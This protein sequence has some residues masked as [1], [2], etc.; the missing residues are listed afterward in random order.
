MSTL[1][2]TGGR[3]LR[4]RLRVP[5]DKS[6]S[7]RALLLAARAKGTSVIRGLSSGDDVSRTSTAIE[8]L[9]AV[10]NGSQVTGGLRLLHE[11]GGVI[12]VG[13]SGT[14]IRLLAGLVAAFGWRTELRGDAS[15]AARPMDRVTTPLRLMGARVDGREDG[16]FPPL[17]VH[18]GRL[19]GI[20]YTPPVA[21]AQAKSAVL[22][23]GLG[24]DGE[25]IVREPVPT[26]A[27][28]EELLAACG[29][30]I[31]VDDD[32][33][34]IRVRPSQLEPFELVI[35]GD[36]SQAAFW[37]VAACIVPGSE[38]V[39]ED[40]YVGQAR[41]GFVGVLRRMGADVELEP[42]GDHRA[43][44]VARTS[45][46]VMHGTEV[47][48]DE[49]AGLIDEIPVLAVAGAVA[50]GTTLFREVGELRVKESD[51]IDTMT[52][53][54]SALGAT[55]REPGPGL[56]EVRQARLSGATVH[57]HG[58]HRVAMSLAVAALAAEGTTK[59]EGWEAVATSYPCF[60]EDLRAC[61]S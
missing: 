1:S 54:L 15:I 21:S 53:E 40:V 39:I 36:P 55:V 5:G 58:D 4:G 43:D 35:P 51:R 57:S 9:G 61:L 50:D 25:T 8:A 23:A 30:D 48:G 28:T 31:S 6:I 47:T 46:D 45:L 37:A 2:I 13:N 12:D 32:G 19:H 29:A 60:E 11:P 24:A 22:L 16:R 42:T 14:T 41:T 3:P 44:I 18:G 7:H 59:I 38:L 17:V 34:C 27:H 10:V 49:I 52:K 56:L 20:D 33:R 26:R